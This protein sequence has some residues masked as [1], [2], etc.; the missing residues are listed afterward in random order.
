ME[1]FKLLYILN[2]LNDAGF[3]T[4]TYNPKKD[5]ELEDFFTKLQEQTFGKIIK[6]DQ[7]SIL[8][9]RNGKSKRVT[10]KSKKRYSS[11]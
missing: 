3:H 11:H 5:G 7:T 10:A 2:L 1:A 9:D 8:K 4:R 6:K